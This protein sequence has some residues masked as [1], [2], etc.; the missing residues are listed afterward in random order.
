[1]INPL[2][3][4]HPQDWWIIATA[5]TCAVACALVGCFL[6]LRKLSMMGD[7]VSHAVLPGLVV[8][9]LLSGSRDTLPMLVGALVVGLLTAYLTELV[10]SSGKVDEGASMGVVFTT[11][12]ALGLLLV[13]RFS[14]KI[15]LDPG[16]VLYGNLELV[17][18]DT[19]LVLGQP[20]PHAFLVL[21]AILA[22]NVLV[23]S[24]FYKELKLSSFDPALATAL[25]V[26]ARLMHYLLM[27]LVALTTVASFQAVGSIL[28]VAMLVVPAATASLLTQ[29]LIPM[30][31]VS[32]GVGIVSAFAGHYSAIVVPAMFGYDATLTSGM[33]AV[34]AGGLLVLAV[35][36]SP[37]HGLVPRVVRRMLL[38]ID[39]A[40]DDVLATLY[41]DEEAPARAVRLDPLSARPMLRGVARYLLHRSG[42]LARNELTPAGRDHARK[43]LRSHRLWE[44]FLS[45]Q[46]AIRPDHT[47]R[48]AERLEHITDADLRN[49]LA[50]SSPHAPATT[51]PQGRDIPPE[52]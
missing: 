37:V 1:M 51:D 18:M 26:P 52:K 43:L 20:I 7:A 25:G 11:L 49:A 45:E 44:T 46:A 28:V 2:T 29:R 48:S 17:P 9:F 22:L 4:F 12:F 16:C 10:R 42:D 36:F 15:D 50:E 14:D 39:E 34:A 35:L 32:A 5:G 33:M 23:I 47:H 40:R 38:R 21:A 13:V 6:L 41:R 8:G 19:R 24:V 3:D 30:L 31:L 27:T